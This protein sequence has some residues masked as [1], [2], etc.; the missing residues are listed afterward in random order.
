MK[1]ENFKELTD[2]DLRDR[3]E[4]MEKDYMQL[5]INHKVSPIDNPARITADRRAIARAK[6]E[7]RLRELSAK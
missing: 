7:L 3:L 6:T 4:Q 1:K 5:K 2:Q